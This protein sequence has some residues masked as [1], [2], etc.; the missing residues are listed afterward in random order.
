M[1]PD[2]KKRFRDYGFITG[3]LPTGPRNT[4]ADVPGV[5]VGHL[6]KIEGDDV[7]TGVTVIDP[8]VQDLYSKKI[9]AAIAVGNGHGKLAGITEVEEM[10]VLEVPV[11]LTNTHA[12][13]AVMAGIIT[14]VRRGMREPAWTDSVNAV[15]SEVNDGRLNNIHKES[16]VPEDVAHA[17]TALTDQVSIG[18]IGAGTGSR[19]F[20]WKGGI[21]TASR[22]ITVN[23]KKYTLGVLS[24][25]NFGGA[26]T[27]LG[28][29]VWQL[30]GKN[31]FHLQEQPKSDGS[32]NTVLATDAPL[33]A[34]QLKRIAARTFLGLGKTGGVLNT[35]SGEYAIAF[36]TSR[37]G[38]EGSG[39][40]GQCL[41]DNDLMHF[42]LAA[43]EATEE[44]IYDALFAAE[45]MHGWQGRVLEALPKGPVIEMLKK[46][47]I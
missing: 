15:V 20:S 31:D 9:P 16:I 19:A 29:P 5:R 6:T 12:V 25:T 47:I 13:G 28:V 8:S 34:R 18:N 44:S 23:D 11:A 35:T 41:S 26:L 38:V 10:G 2:S 32:Q 22:V 3:L 21:G 36:T 46:Q 42:F 27:M 45:T 14:H 1:I 4:I 30:F 43:V 39:V 17:L 37:A 33:T 40:V 24:Q 7:R